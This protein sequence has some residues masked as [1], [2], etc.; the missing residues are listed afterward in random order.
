LGLVQSN[1][2]FTQDGKVR[3]FVDE[4]SDRG[5]DPLAELKFEAGSPG[6]VAKDVFKALHPL[7]S[8]TFKK[9]ETGHADTF[10]LKP[11]E[12]GKRYLRDRIKAGGAILIVI[13]PADEEVVTAYLRDRD[14]DGSKVFGRVNDQRLHR[15]RLTGGAIGEGTTQ[16]D[17]GNDLATILAT[18]AQRGYNARVR[19]TVV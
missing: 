18:S 6:G 7:G 4:P 13:V 3:F 2:R 17:D 14:R 16:F 5:T 8:G 19:I 9:V 1:G 12:A 15:A 10:E 11:D